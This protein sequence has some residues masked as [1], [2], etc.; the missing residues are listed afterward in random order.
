MRDAFRYCLCLFMVEAGKLC[1][2]EKRSSE[3]ALDYVRLAG[4][5]AGE[6]AG[7]RV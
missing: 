7:V 2:V 1:L 3:P 4:R 5:Q 6:R